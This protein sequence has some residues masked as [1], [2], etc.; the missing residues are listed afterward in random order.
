MEISCGLTQIVQVIV[1]QIIL[2]V[3]VQSENSL[4]KL[5][6]TQFS[7]ALCEFKVFTDIL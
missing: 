5:I 3:Q 2:I 1:K 6:K 4:H 7:K